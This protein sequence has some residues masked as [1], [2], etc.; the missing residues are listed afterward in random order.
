MVTIAVFSYSG[1]K[2]RMCEDWKDLLYIDMYS[3]FFFVFV[4]GRLT[5][6]TCKKTVTRLYRL[7]L[8]CQNTSAVF[9]PTYQMALVGS[10]ATFSGCVVARINVSSSEGAHTSVSS[11]S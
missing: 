5:T 2:K 6:D 7:L 11:G 3:P 4:F 1:H 10:A 9:V 8:S